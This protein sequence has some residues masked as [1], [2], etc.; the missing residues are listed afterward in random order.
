MGPPISFRPR[1]PM[2]DR[3]RPLNTVI[4]GH[5]A[6]V[7]SAI[8]TEAA[9]RLSGQVP[10]FRVVAVCDAGYSEHPSRFRRS[11]KVIGESALTWLFNPTEPVFF[12]RELLASICTVSRRHGVDMIVPR[13]RNIN[14]PEFI[15]FLRD[16]LRPDLALSFGC[17]QIFGKDLMDVFEACVNY[18]I[19][20]LPDYRGWGATEW[21]IYHGESRTGFTWH[22]MT[23][24][25]D[26]G[27]ILDRDSV[28]VGN[29]PVVRLQYE[30]T[31]LAAT[32]LRAV[33]GA[34]ADGEVGMPQAGPSKYYALKDLGKITRVDPGRLTWEE[35]RHR[36]RSFG[37]LR[38]EFEG[39][40]YPVT[41]IRRLRPGARRRHTF[42]TA[43]GV[44]A[45]ATRFRRLP[46][47]I[48]R[49]RQK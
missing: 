40:R 18:H 32:R 41:R 39:N 29:H 2:T 17:T 26:G 42:V 12:G 33:V 27:P 48:Y 7:K 21:S 14:H 43:D 20:I 3:I 23:G 15:A 6:D 47:R 34:I 25:I 13:E 19:G 30:K 8:L 36:L 1:F 4:F 24:K 38:M 44:E 45:V 46:Y 22:Y 35:L 31:K 5:P 11:I 28:P 10:G 9:L 49:L 16:E 37:V